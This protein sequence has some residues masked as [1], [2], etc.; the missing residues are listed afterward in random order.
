MN[1][2]LTLCYKCL[3]DF[4]NK[5]QTKVRR[6]DY[7]QITKEPC[8]YCQVRYGYDYEIEELDPSTASRNKSHI[9]KKN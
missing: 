6:V 2:V 1:M 8:C 5:P 4:R 9:G 7:T 3:N